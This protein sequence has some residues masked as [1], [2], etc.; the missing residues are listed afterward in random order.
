MDGKNNI[1]NVKR[2]LDGKIGSQDDFPFRTS[3][4]SKAERLSAL[5]QQIDRATQ[6][7]STIDDRAMADFL[8]TIEGK[9]TTREELAQA[10]TIAQRL[11]QNPEILSPE[12]QSQLMDVPRAIANHRNADYS[13]QEESKNI[14]SKA[15]SAIS[16]LS[17]EAQKKLLEKAVLMANLNAKG[18]VEILSNI[19]ESNAEGVDGISKPARSLFISLLGNTATQVSSMDAKAQASFQEAAVKMMQGTQFPYKFDADSFREA[20]R[21]VPE[22]TRSEEYKAQL[23]ILDQNSAPEIPVAIVVPE[24]DLGEEPEVEPQPE[25]V[26]EEYNA[27]LAILEKNPAPG[28]GQLPYIILENARPKNPASQAEKLDEDAA[29]QENILTAKAE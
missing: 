14:V 24:E 8:G 4:A 19:A 26:S 13:L 21:A 15:A 23:A 28:E 29:N 3:Q 11:A 10:A 20:L 17:D 9:S 27:Q 2:P 18:A 5:Q 7:H 22:S 25:D 12:A 6:Q 16:S 1:E